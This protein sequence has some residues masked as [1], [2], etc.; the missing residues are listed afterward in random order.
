MAQLTEEEVLDGVREELAV[1]KVPGAAEAT[2]ETEWRDL[3][4]DSLELVEL[5]TALEDR[6]GVKIADGEL[7]SIQGVGD[8]V[9]LT[10]PARQRA[11]RRVSVAVTG[12]GVVTSLGEGADEFFDA[13]LAGRSGIATASRRQR[14]STPSATS[15]RVPPRRMDRFTQLRPRRG[16]RGRRRGEDLRL[17]PRPRRGPARHRHRR[18]RHAAGPVRRHS[19]PR[20]SAASPRTSCR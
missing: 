8:A 2:M 12:R 19:S 16:H 11:G 13:L 14:S 18:P 4:I 15:T 20:A 7:R 10:P 6:F 17:R 5:V 3:D 9:R 1:L